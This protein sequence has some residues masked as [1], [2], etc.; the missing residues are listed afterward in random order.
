MFVKTFTFPL[1][2]DHKIKLI[3]ADH[4]EDDRVAKLLNDDEDWLSNKDGCALDNQHGTFFIVLYTPTIPVL[5]HECLHIVDY[6]SEKFCVR[7]IEFKCM[8]LEWML[9]KMIPYV[10]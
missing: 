4:E 2:E 6:A 8:L 10:K 1:R 5:A 9:I 7:D 3:L